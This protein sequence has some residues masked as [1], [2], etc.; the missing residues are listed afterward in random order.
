[1]SNAN[2]AAEAQYIQGDLVRAVQTMLR[3]RL[4]LNVKGAAECERLI[5]ENGEGNTVLWHH[6]EYLPTTIKLAQAILHEVAET[7]APGAAG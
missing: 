3:H 5:R 7:I 4:P 2:V 6:K 1:M